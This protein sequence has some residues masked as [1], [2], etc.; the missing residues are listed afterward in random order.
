MKQS[1]F[2]ILCGALAL[3]SLSVGFIGAIYENRKEKKHKPAATFRDLY[4]DNAASEPY[5]EL[6]DMS[7][8]MEMFLFG[9][10]L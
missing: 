2:F 6:S 10:W 3:G 7:P 4:E 1:T 8:E 5:H 9:G